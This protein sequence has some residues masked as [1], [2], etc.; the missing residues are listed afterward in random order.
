[1]LAPREEV[2]ELPH[3]GVRGAGA[4]P[5]S[6]GDIAASPPAAGSEPGSA[7]Q[8]NAAR[9]GSN[10]LADMPDHQRRAQASARLQ[11]RDVLRGFECPETECRYEAFLGGGS[12]RLERLALTALAA[13][14]LLGI[15]LAGWGAVSTLPVGDSIDAGSAGSVGG[16]GEGG[17]DGYCLLEG[18]ARSGPVGDTTCWLSRQGYVFQV[19]VAAVATMGLLGLPAAVRRRA[20]MGANAVQRYGKHG[21]TEGNP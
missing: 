3:Q 4:R 11:L 1:M 15:T 2:S 16:G 20:D 19:L 9:S 13:L 8:Q 21:C 7:G 12:T 14:V 17:S 5:N 18:G 6:I 10:D